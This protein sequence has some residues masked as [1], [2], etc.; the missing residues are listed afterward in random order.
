MKSDLQKSASSG[1]VK[2]LALALGVTALALTCLAWNAVTSIRKI[3]NVK[4]REL[5]SEE[6]RGSIVHL[7][8]VLTMS[9]LMATATG[10]PRWEARYREFEPKLGRAIDEAE[11]LAVRDG[12]AA[13]VERT[14]VANA[15]LV[16]M[17]NRAFELVRRRRLEA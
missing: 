1:P 15:A 3:E 8:E 10:D 12:G 16:R 13:V 7:D 9:A 2:A 14:G 6:L 17:E 5:R 4:Q 11:S